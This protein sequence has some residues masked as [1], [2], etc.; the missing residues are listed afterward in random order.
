[1]KLWTISDIVEDWLIAHGYDGLVNSDY[2]CGCLLGDTAPCG[3]GCA[4]CAA[5]YRWPCT[6]ET[7]ENNDCDPDP[8]HPSPFCMRVDKPTDTDSREG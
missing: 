1:M 5:A 7:C 2:A 3:D 4:D 6:P 8:K